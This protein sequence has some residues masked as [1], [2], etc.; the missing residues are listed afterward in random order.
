MA[1]IWKFPFSVI[2]DRLVIEM[3][4]GALPLSVQVQHNQPTLWAIVDPE[5]EIVNHRFCLVGTG[6]STPENVG[7]FIGTFQM[8]DGSL[9]F[10]LF[11][12]AQKEVAWRS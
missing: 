2:D 8:F 9:V 11:E 4:R 7:R 1:T 6:H 12:A 3:P 5:A 10:H